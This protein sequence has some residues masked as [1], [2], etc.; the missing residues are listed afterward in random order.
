MSAV[1][2]CLMVAILIFIAVCVAILKESA[3]TKQVLSNRKKRSI[4][5]I[6]IMHYSWTHCAVQRTHD[7]TP[8]NMHFN[9]Q[10]LKYSS[11]P[12]SQTITTCLHTRVAHTHT[13]THSDTHT[14]THAQWHTH[15]RTVTHTHTHS[16]T[17]TGTR[18]VTHT[19]THRHTH[20]S[21][22][23][24]T[25]S[26]TMIS[27]SLNGQYSQ[28]QQIESI[29]SPSPLISHPIPFSFQDLM[30]SWI[31]CIQN[32]TETV[33]AIIFNC[34]FASLICHV[35][36]SKNKT[37]SENNDNNNTMFRQSVPQFQKLRFY[38][39]LKLK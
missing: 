9:K 13:H 17:H 11:L 20:T 35:D 27:K 23:L 25:H 1:Q 6:L 28:Q 24:L 16:D 36:K 33:R 7:K 2:E 29:F 31:S 12:W 5:I 14:H 30:H 15:T 39:P 3:F 18:T 32:E 4:I 19:H 10:N 22:S 34:L 8:I 38:G 37:E 26:Y 21:Q